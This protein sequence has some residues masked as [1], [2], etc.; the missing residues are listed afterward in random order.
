[1]G[2]VRESAE[3]LYEEWQRFDPQVPYRDPMCLYAISKDI[4]GEL[5]YQDH[6]DH[7]CSS[8]CVTMKNLSILEV[9]V[10]AGPCD[11]AE[12]ASLDGV[13]EA[14]WVAAHEN[15]GNQR[16]VHGGKAK[17]GGAGSEAAGFLAGL[18]N[19]GT[20]R[21]PPYSCEDCDR[22]GHLEGRFRFAILDGKHQGCVAVG[23]YAIEYD[24]STTGISTA[25][26][27]IMEG[28]IVC[29]C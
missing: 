29:D 16:G 19:A 15:D 21:A 10:T 20:H 25:V 23:Q 22:H 7:T 26:H 5:Q 13:I 18:N 9:R 4:E 6:H 12:A 2:W 24:A 17:W 14:Q 11:S 27:G 8:G 1:M 28:S 3:R